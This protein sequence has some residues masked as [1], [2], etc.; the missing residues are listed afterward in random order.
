[1]SATPT[2]SVRKSSAL[3]QLNRRLP[4]TPAHIGRVEDFHLRMGAPPAGRTKENGGVRE[5]FA[6]P[7]RA[8]LPTDQG[9]PHGNCIGASVHWTGRAR[10][11]E[12]ARIP[13]W[14]PGQYE[15]STKSKPR[16]QPS[17]PETRPNQRLY[18]PLGSPPLVAVGSSSARAAHRS[19]APRTRGSKNGLDC[20]ASKGFQAAAQM[21]N[22]CTQAIAAVAASPKGS[23]SMPCPSPGRTRIACSLESRQRRLS[24][25]SPSDATRS[26]ADRRAARTTNAPT[27]SPAESYSFLNMATNSFQFQGVR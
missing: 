10:G 11:H 6:I 24:L 9:R 5:D 2:F 26:D 7:A 19:R 3:P 8:L 27:P 1:V 14:H 12:P 20:G 16:H 15:A 4:L 17:R 13:E 25:D 21:R 23:T 22:D 18:V